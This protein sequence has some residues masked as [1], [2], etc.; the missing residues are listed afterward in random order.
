MRECP[1]CKNKDVYLIESGTIF[2]NFF[3]IFECSFCGLSF[4]YEMKEAKGEHYELT[5]WYGERWEFGEVLKS[6]D[7]RGKRLLEIG[8]GK[9]Y[10]LKK[11]EKINCDV[12]GIDI[13]KQAINFAKNELSLKNVF[14][15]EL[16][17]F[18]KNNDLNFDVICFFH[19]LEHLEN[20]KDFFHK[21]SKILNKNGFLCISFPNPNRLS[22]KIL[23]REYWDYPP[24]H[25]TRWNE[26]SIKYLLNLYNFEIVKI[27]E[28]PLSLFKCTEDVGVF[29]QT[30]HFLRKNR[31][32]YKKGEKKFFFSLKRFLKALFMIAFLPFGFIVY[33]IGK[34]NKL[35]GQAM[36]IIARKDG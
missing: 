12:Y 13:N 3:E 7:L 31:M 33:I 20:P 26:K 34:L 6:I 19:V 25:L 18:L 24:H 16:K 1:L 11:V 36:L 29:F 27:S 5:E 23:K 10:F 4:S 9:G 8:C 30:I 32:R 28:E 21:V 2:G 17:E 15:L 14:S 22:L 35:N